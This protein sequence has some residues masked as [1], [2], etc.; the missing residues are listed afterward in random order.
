MTDEW[1]EKENQYRDA[2]LEAAHEWNNRID[3]EWDE[4]RQAYIK[5]QSPEMQTKDYCLLAGLIVII[6]ILALLPPM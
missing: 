3:Y 4:K 5:K 1:Q 2:M 6:I